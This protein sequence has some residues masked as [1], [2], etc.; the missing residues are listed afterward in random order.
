MTG[1]Q[2]TRPAA[3]VILLRPAQPRGFEVFLIRRPMG[4][5]FLGGMHCFPG[6][7]V[8]KSD[9]STAM[10]RSCYGLTP[11]QARKIL[12]AHFSPAEAL[13]FWVAGIREIFEEV[14]ILFAVDPN[15]ATFVPDEN[16][17]I[18]LAGHHAALLERSTN[19]Q[20]LLQ[21][22][23]L[24]CD[25]AKLAYF[26]HWQTPAQFSLRFDMYFFV[27]ALPDDQTPL[28]TSPE[29]AHGRWLSPDLAL[30]LFAKNDLPMIFP[31][32]AALRT[33][34]DFDSLDSVA[35]EYQIEPS[36]R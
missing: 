21:M 28:S 9:C 3:T 24:M 23:N 33:L 11:N 27:A 7:T 17:K 4:M 32:F 16:G 31:T 6:G 29:V 12:G 10:L 20:A 22:E 25:A 1:I 35:R 15:G 36:A 14:A 13:G 19:F 30:E 26:S 5:A 34:A 8:T 18:R 2:K